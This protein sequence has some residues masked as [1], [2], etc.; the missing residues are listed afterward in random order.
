MLSSR[1]PG[2]REI[3]ESMNLTQ[4]DV[5]GTS[6]QGEGPS[7]SPPTMGWHSPI[8]QL[9]ALPSKALVWHWEAAPVQG[10]NWEL[11]L[12]QISAFALWCLNTV[13]HL[14]DLFLSG[15]KSY[16]INRWTNILRQPRH[17]RNWR[18]TV[19]SESWRVTWP[20]FLGIILSSD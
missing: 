5:T 15:Q 20:W 6:V 3:V 18:V 10:R 19:M 7:W 8:S 2:T 17:Q 12:L 11:L 16:K 14:Q 9:S 1:L 4:F 13:L